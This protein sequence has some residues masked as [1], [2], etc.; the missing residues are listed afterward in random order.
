MYNYYRGLNRDRSFYK[1]GVN[2]EKNRKN[3][4]SSAIPEIENK[5]GYAFKDKSL[6]RQAFTRTSYCNENKGQGGKAYQSN[7]VLEFFGDS[8]LSSAI[9][10]LIIK[11]CSERYEYGVFTELREGDF[12]NIKSKLSDKKNLS[13]RVR[14]IGLSRFLLMGEGDL[15]L[16]VENEPSVMEDLFESII[17]A[18]YIDSGMDM[19]KVIK[20]VSGMLSIKEYLS[21]KAVPKQSAKNALQ[22]WCA[23]KKRRLPAP[24]YSTVSEKGPEHKR[25]YER[26]CS[27]GDR[28]YAVGMGKNQKI[29][30]ADAAEKTLKILMQEEGL[31]GAKNLPDDSSVEKLME[32]LTSK[33]LT[34]LS[35]F[36]LGECE[37]STP[38]RQ[39]FKV[40]CKIGDKSVEGVG[41]SKK[42]AR[43]DSAHKMLML[44]KGNAPSQNK[45]APQKKTNQKRI[46]K[47]KT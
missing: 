41:V 42:G 11:E 6:L 27:I 2:M 28:V 5:I 1:N 16:G 21:V 44:L 19:P 36:D 26:S 32:Y 10:S 31:R 37:G 12:S 39:K 29:A 24:V 46:T 45:K 20:V 8:V 38:Q 13:D 40:G 47:N 18:V 7:E 22:E 4:F 15:K 17:G 35:F 25:V 33:K 43:S 3:D 23:D 30:D 34:G 14:E 9:V